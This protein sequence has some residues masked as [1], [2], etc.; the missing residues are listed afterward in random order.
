[1][2]DIDTDITDAR[3]TQKSDGYV[4][5]RASNFQN[6]LLPRVVPRTKATFV[7][8]PA[9]GPLK[10][11]PEK[12][13][14]GLRQPNHRSIRYDESASFTRKPSVFRAFRWLN[15]FPATALLGNPSTDGSRGSDQ[16]LIHCG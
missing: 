14:L 2:V 5:T 12:R 1:M 7:H 16:T 8:C 9:N 13:Q 11:V 10:A 4:A 3:P 6:T 15:L